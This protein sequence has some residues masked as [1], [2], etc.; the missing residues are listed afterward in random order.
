M[1]LFPARYAASVRFDAIKQAKK[2]ARIRDV[3][4]F[5]ET[6]LAVAPV[7]EV[8][9]PA[10]QAMQRAGV[11]RR[12]RRTTLTVTA[13]AVTAAVATAAYV[14]WRRHEHDGAGPQMPSRA[15]DVRPAVASGRDEPD[16]AEVRS[17][18]IEAVV[19]AAAEGGG[20]ATAAGSEAMSATIEPQAEATPPTRAAGRPVS[21]MHPT[22]TVAMGHNSPV[23]A[24]ADE[25]C[26]TT[27]AS[28]PPAPAVAAQTCGRVI[29]PPGYQ[30]PNRRFALPSSVPK[31]PSA[32]TDSLP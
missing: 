19:P 10:S 13:V 2:M 5:A 12:G 25:A 28:R 1:S 9:R 18:G 32:R 31:L 21:V 22:P 30:S 17:E 29:P 11:G 4:E 16:D 3:R 15:S 20:F 23:A 7:L 8:P 24:A 14:W 27:G 26:M 6:R